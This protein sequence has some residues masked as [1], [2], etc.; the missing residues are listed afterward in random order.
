MYFDPLKDRIS[1]KEYIRIQFV[2]HRK[3]VIS[4]LKISR[5]MLFRKSIV[6]YYDTL[7]KHAIHSVGRKQSSG[8][9]KQAVGIQ[10]LGFKRLNK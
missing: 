7:K 2:P 3:H 6:I 10:P 9:L 5:L 8:I 1:S 4:R